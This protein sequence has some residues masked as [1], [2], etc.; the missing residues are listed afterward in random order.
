MN[1]YDV[2]DLQVGNKFDKPVYID[3]TTVLVEENIPISEDDIKKLMRWGVLSVFTEGSMIEEQKPDTV[4]EV[5]GPELTNRIL[6]QY[7]ELLLKRKDLVAV[8]QETCQAVEQIY[9]AI[10]SSQS[11]QIEILYKPLDKI[12]DLISNYK[13][14]FLFLYG[15]GEDKDHFVV[16]SVNVTFYAVLIGLALKYPPEKL[17][18]LG[19]GSLLID[20]G[21]VKLPAYI[22]HKQSDL[23]EHEFKLIKTHP[24]H[25]YKVLK[26]LGEIPEMSAIISLQHHEQFDG[27]GYPTGKKGNQIHEFARIATIAD[28]YEAQVESRSYR[29]KQFFYEAMRNLLANGSKSFDPVILRVFISRLS[30]YPIG[31]LVQLNTNVIGLVIGSEPSKPLRPFLKLI[32]NAN[33]KRVEDLQVISLL[34]DNSLYIVKSLSEAEVGVNLY[35]IL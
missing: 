18:A 8:H 30:I 32:F 16:H 3:N 27:H 10:K 34:D 23:T 21:M 24:L 33:K 17:R 2:E 6:K 9:Q 13:N 7:N 14:I 20:S 22:A 19:I 31:S 1:K 35:E 5:S 25:G 15:L 12:I 4:V 11:F 29:K 28:S 26:Q